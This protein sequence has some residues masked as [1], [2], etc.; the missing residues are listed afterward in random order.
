MCHIQL[1]EHI[2]ES[3]SPPMS[4]R[5]ILPIKNIIDKPVKKVN[6]GWISNRM[7]NNI[8]IIIVQKKMN[9]ISTSPFD[10]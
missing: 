1:D 3:L 6:T 5:K 4:L 10:N 8:V 7:L 9:A 2:Q